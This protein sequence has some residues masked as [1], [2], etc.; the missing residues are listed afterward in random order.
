MTIKAYV[1]ERNEAEFRWEV[2]DTR[3]NRIAH[4][5]VHHPDAESCCN[6]LNYWV[7]E[8]EKTLRGGI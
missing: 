8:T 7:Q 1:V 4:A 3:T 2:R 6:S 5:F